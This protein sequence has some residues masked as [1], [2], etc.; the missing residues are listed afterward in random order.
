M[1]KHD[2][3]RSPF[4][5]ALEPRL[6]YDGAAAGEALQTATDQSHAADKSASDAQTPDQLAPE[7]VSHNATRSP[8]AKALE[9][10]AQARANGEAES[11]AVFVDSKALSD[12]DAA[13]RALF[14]DARTSDGVDVFVVDHR[15]AGL[16]DIEATLSERPPYD[17][18]FVV[19][20]GRGSEAAIG[21]SALA[22][23]SAI[24]N[25]LINGSSVSVFDQTGESITARDPA[26]L[27]L[28]EGES[29]L[30]LGRC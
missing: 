27:S 4:I 20:D 3:P 11:A 28:T 8:L 22:D 18:T 23:L 10:S 17:A 14:E 13:T 24:Q 9:A 29:T 7:Q 6:L 26:N 19:A 30:A 12:A 25:T 2:L 15:S 1:K 21:R 16:A 5:R